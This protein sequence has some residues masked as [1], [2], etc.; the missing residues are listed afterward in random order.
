[1]GKGSIFSF[2]LHLEKEKKQ[3]EVLPTSGAS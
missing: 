1:L 3:E 2:E